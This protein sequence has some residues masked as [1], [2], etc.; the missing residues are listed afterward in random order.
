MDTAFEL[1]LDNDRDHR[2]QDL[3]RVLLDPAGMGVMHAEGARRLSDDPAEL[4]HNNGTHRRGARIERH[5]VGA[6]EAK[7]RVNEPEVFK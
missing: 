1:D 3:G 5:D 4:V 2:R 7:R 6:A